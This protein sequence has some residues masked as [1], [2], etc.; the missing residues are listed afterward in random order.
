MATTN[1]DINLMKDMRV[2][3]GLPREPKPG[4]F[5]IPDIEDSLPEEKRYPLYRDKHGVIHYDQ[6]GFPIMFPDA[7]LRERRMWNAQSNECSG[8]DYVL[9]PSKSAKFEGWF[10]LGEVSLIGGSSGAG[11]TTWAL[12]MLEAQFRGQEFLGH[13]TYELPYIILMKD[14]SKFGLRRTFRRLET[15]CRCGSFQRSVPRRCTSRTL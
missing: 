6:E 9:G 12:Q 15:T 1:A 14:R 10:P 2:A 8:E 7:T 3:M 4:E 5:L 13:E 11:K